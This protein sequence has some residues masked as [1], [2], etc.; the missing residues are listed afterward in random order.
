MENKKTEIYKKWWFWLI[1]ILILGFIGSL[2]NNNS[3]KNDDS[4]N[5]VPTSSQSAQITAL[6]GTNAEDF[7]NILCDVAGL[8]KNEPQDLNDALIYESANTI[9]NIEI[10]SNKNKEI[11]SIRIINVNSQDCEN[12]FIALTRLEYNGSN[13]STLFDFIHNNINKEAEIT[14]GDASFKIYKGT[15]NKPIIEL[16]IK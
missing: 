11:Q 10:V 1:V 12:L 5:D 9:Y 3:P 14:I 4:T 2:G 6:S 8:K 15:N 16:Y 7:Y 13:K